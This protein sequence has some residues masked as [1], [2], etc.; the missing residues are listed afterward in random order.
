MTGANAFANLERS[1]IDQLA[2]RHGFRGRGPR[3]WSRHKG[4]FVQLVNLQRSQWSK[5]ITYLNFALWPLVLGEPR[6]FA[7]S[8]F[9]FRTRGEHMSAEDLPGFFAE[10]D[11]LTTLSELAEALRTRRISGGVRK[12]LVPLLP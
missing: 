1:E 5:D 7:E 8:K 2:R 6:S 12:E 3:T 10:A 9:L 4:E 11:K